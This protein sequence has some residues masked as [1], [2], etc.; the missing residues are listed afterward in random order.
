V[1]KHKITPQAENFSQWY[2]DIVLQ[3]Q[4]AD[5]TPVKGCMVILPNGY[6]IWEKIQKEL[7]QRI[8]ATGV[9]N[10]Y[11]PTLIPES[12]LSKEA[13]HVKGFA[14]QCAIVTHV[15]NQVLEDKL[16]VRPTSETLIHYLFSQWIHSYRDLPYL[17]NQWVNVVRWEMKTR[18]FLRSNEFLWQEGHT[19]HVDA[20]EAQYRAQ[21]M[22]KLYQ[23]FMQEILAIPV[24][25]GIKSET[26]KFAGAIQTYTI[27]A[28]M[29]DKKALQLGT[30]HYF[31]NRFAKAFKIQYLSQ[32]NEL[33]WVYQTS[34]GVSTRMIGGVIMAHS[35]DRGLVLPPRLAFLHVV[36]VPIFSGN[37]ELI[38]KVA[39]N[40]KDCIQQEAKG[41]DFWRDI[42]IKIDQDESKK[43][44][45]KFYQYE[46]LGVPIRIEIGP[47]ELELQQVYVVRRD[48]LN[49]KK[50][51]KWDNLAQKVLE[52]LENMQHALF[53]KAHAFKKANTMEIHT[54]EEFKMHSKNGMGVLIA[55]WCQKKECEAWINEKTKF[56]IRCL[57]VDE[58]MQL[59]KKP[60]KKC[61]C[62]DQGKIIQA[63]FARNY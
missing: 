54:W 57:P 49:Q 32:E 9:Q 20:N 25:S 27:E 6:A 41:V 56:T 17:I 40:L 16:V 44:G 60:G 62:G 48:I 14:P 45:W 11:F 42:Q 61:L 8:K 58:E 4:L 47:K 13:E 10:A 5:Y 36:I 29:Q 24:F 55:P 33:H 35:D 30:S 2:Q 19:C 28:L 34:W 15:G 21:M 51:V 31:G 46:L 50:I 7:D 38:L 39:Q 53:E 37:K 23:K 52:E 18:P 59:I 26:E 12:F 43:T 63:I 22:L 1:I 3:A